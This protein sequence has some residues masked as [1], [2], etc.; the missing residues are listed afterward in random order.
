MTTPLSRLVAVPVR[1]VWTHEASEFTPWL[2][3]RENVALLAE[4]LRLGELEVEATERSVGRFS[5]DIVARDEGGALV[6]IENQL[7]PTDHRHLGQVLTYLAGLEGDATV[8]WIATRFLEEHRAAI[9]WLNANTNDH[10]DFFGIE[11]EL[12]RIGSSPPAPRFNIVA[13]PNDWS[14]EVRSTT[15]T[16]GEAPSNE[17]QRL[18]L[19]YWNSFRSFCTV[20]APTFRLSAAWARQWWPTRIGRTGFNINGVIGREQRQIRVELYIQLRGQAPKIAFRALQ[21]E[22]ESIERE[23]GYPLSWEELPTRQATRIA[24]YKDNVDV[25]ERTSWLGQHRWMLDRMLDFRR[26]FSQRV[27]GLDLDAYD[28]EEA[29]EPPV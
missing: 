29:S 11:V 20:E 28:A 10:F 8:V 12:F 5:A 21:A 3:Q 25:T 23:L 15:R 22:K 17:L 18:Y 9:D 7:E 13:K 6:L 14:R 16:L 4:T 26:V 24:I 27:R 1:D 19:D 2:A